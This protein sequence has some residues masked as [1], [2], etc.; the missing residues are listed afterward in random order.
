MSK[1]GLEEEGHGSWFPSEL[2]LL[3]DLKPC[4]GPSGMGLGVPGDGCHKHVPF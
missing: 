1:P 2:V 3:G 4:A